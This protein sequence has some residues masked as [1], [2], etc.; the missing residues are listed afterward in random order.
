[1]RGLA[2]I[3]VSASDSEELRLRKTVLVLSSTLIACLALVWVATFAVLG[4][5]VSAAIPFAYQVASALGIYTFARTRHYLLFRR[6]QLWTCLVLP[7][8]VGISGHASTAS[9]SS[10]YAIG[11]S[12]A[13][14]IAHPALTGEAPGA[15]KMRASVTKGGPPVV[16]LIGPP[17]LGELGFDVVDP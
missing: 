4:L 16:T 17:A 5:W 11:S 8:V 6:S 1:V 12:S 3:G 9:R 10:R 14:E 2:D 7:F 15:A 13:R